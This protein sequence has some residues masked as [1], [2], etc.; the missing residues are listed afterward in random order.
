MPRM[1]SNQTKQCILVAGGTG[2]LGRLVVH[3]LVSSGAAVRTLSRRP[4]AANAL[5]ELGVDV[6][7]ADATDAA[8]LTGVC[9]GVDVVCSCLGASVSPTSKERRGFA[10]IDLPANHNLLEEARRA[11]VSR[12]VYVAAFS[13]PG[14]ADTAYARAHEAFAEELA[15]SGIP[16]AV[17]RPT[18]LFSVFGEIL[19]NAR[20][21]P[22]PLIGSGESRTNPIH[23]ADVAE[24]CVEAIRSTDPALTIDCGGPEVLSRREIMQACFDALGK[25][26]SLMKMPPWFMRFGAGAAGI[27]NRRLGELLAFAIAVSTHDCVA[28]ERGRRRLGDYL[29]ERAGAS[30]A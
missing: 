1:T 20:R 24:L 12:F 15:Q 2:Q 4:E 30:R 27:F 16:Y 14:W 17:V 29:R 9:E 6:R 5:K 23:D 13:G 3:D 21:G 10:E 18:G 8:A 28:P 11:G 7:L 19:D 25:K 26:G 22:L